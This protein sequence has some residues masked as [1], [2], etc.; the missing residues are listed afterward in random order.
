MGVS[1]LEFQRIFSFSLLI[2]VEINEEPAKIELLKKLKERATSKLQGSEL[3]IFIDQC[4][5]YSK[6][7]YFGRLV[8]HIEHLF[9]FQEFTSKRTI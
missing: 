6:K 1:K 5:D 4:S 8:E 2:V 7:S 9:A 3:S